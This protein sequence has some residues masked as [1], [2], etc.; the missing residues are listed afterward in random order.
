MKS[1][2]EMI[3]LQTLVLE[4]GK[5]CGT[6]TRRDWETIHTRV[7][8]EGWEF[9]GIAL[10]KFGQ[11]LEKAL[12]QGFIDRADFIGWKFNLHPTQSAI[13]VFLSGIIG[14]VFDAERGIPLENPSIP[15]TIALRQITLLFGKMR[16]ETSE[17]RSKAAMR[18][19]IEIDRAIGAFEADFSQIP[20]ISPPD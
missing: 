9:L 1:H 7:E 2:P 4:I 13:P 18:R 12:D 11:A 19:Y 8:H 17:K 6:S 15:A 14:Q 3:L 10:P 5:R 20:M 16:S